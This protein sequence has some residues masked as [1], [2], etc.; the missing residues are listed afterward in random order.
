[1]TMDA[2]YRWN[3]LRLGTPRGGV[4]FKSQFQQRSQSLPTDK[5]VGARDEDA[6]LRFHAG[7]P[8]LSG[9]KGG[10]ARSRS[11]II[12]P[13]VRGQAILKAGSS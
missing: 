12:S 9:M 6:V 13:S 3:I 11:E 2:V 4:H 10:K 1:M 5:S 8:W 7:I